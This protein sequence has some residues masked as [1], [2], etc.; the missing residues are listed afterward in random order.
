M[1][2]SSSKNLCTYKSDD[3][4]ERRLKD[5]NTL[6][7]FKKVSAMEYRFLLKSIVRV[8]PEAIEVNLYSL[9]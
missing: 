1:T 8:A 7:A 9:V 5:L 4:L 3:G 2:K 6:R